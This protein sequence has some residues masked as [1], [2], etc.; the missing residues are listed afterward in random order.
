ME[1]G[2]HGSAQAVMR[3][4]EAETT[5][6]WMKDFEAW[7]ACWLQTPDI[8]RHGWWE[9]GGV[10]IVEGWEAL[11]ERVRQ[12]MANNPTP[13]PE[14]ANVRRENVHVRVT[15]EMAW[16]TFDQ[17]GADTGEPDMDMPG[18][19]YETRI[20]EKHDGQWKIVYVCWLLVPTPVR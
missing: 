12:N 1:Q 18:L 8:R 19:S 15:D 20:L 5:A 3:V 17:Y 2:L 16:V 10:G 13:Q 9:R 14:A 6:F 4:V 11:S 7:A